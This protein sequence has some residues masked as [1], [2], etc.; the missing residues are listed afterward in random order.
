ML[1]RLLLIAGTVCSQ[2]AMAF[3][4]CTLP[5][6]RVAFQ[7]TPCALNAQVEVMRK[8]KPVPV[9]KPGAPAVEPNFAIKVPEQAAALM[10]FYRRWHDSEKLLGSTARISLATPM[11]IA[12]QLQREVDAY[13]AP[14][15]LESAAK[16]LRELIAENNEAMLQFMQKQEVSHMAYSVV[17]RPQKIAAFEQSVQNAICD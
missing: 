11:G 1:L 3:N 16:V 10:A 5:D 14:A 8:P 17:H 15:C 7:D 9:A 6:G 12:Q 2:Q 13:A 4:K